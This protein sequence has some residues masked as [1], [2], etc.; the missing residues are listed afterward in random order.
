[1][2]CGVMGSRIVVIWGWVLL[3]WFEF[4][5]GKGLGDWIKVSG[6]LGIEIMR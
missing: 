5:S 6:D 3:E 2:V 4:R 1:M